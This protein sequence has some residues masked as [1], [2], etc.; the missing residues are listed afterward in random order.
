MLELGY[1]KSKPLAIDIANM[2][3][4]VVAN[5]PDVAKALQSK[6]PKQKTVT[7]TPTPSGNNQTGNNTSPN[8]G[9]QVVSPYDYFKQYIGKDGKFNF[10]PYTMWQNTVMNPNYYYQMFQQY[11]FM[12]YYGYMMSFYGGYQN[13][14][15]MQQMNMGTILMPGSIMYGYMPQMASPMMMPY[16]FNGYNNFYG[17]NSYMQ[18]GFRPNMMPF[19]QTNNQGQVNPCTLS[20]EQ[21]TALTGMVTNIPVNPANTAETVKALQTLK[22]QLDTLIAKYGESLTKPTTTQ[23]QKTDDGRD[24]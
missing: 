16:V 17:Y 11:Q 14:P 15:M 2:V 20:K 12:Q 7:P 24:M 19:Y 6:Q 18:G 1:T 23:Q 9:S 21:I 8:S 13:Y 3:D 10:T 5:S 22:A 4:Y